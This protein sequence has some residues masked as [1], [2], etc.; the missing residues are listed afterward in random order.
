MKIDTLSFINILLSNHSPCVFHAHISVLVPPVV[1]A[2][3]D[4]FYKITSEALLVTQQ[5]VKV[6]R[7]LGKNRHITQCIIWHKIYPRD[8]MFQKSQ[9]MSLYQVQNMYTKFMFFSNDSNMLTTYTHTHTHT[10]TQ[11][12]CPSNNIEPPKYILWHIT[13][14]DI[15]VIGY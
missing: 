4:P 10:Y 15:D 5:L 3:G 14:C 7:P 8:F 6:I 12:F 1:T 11:L 9:D 13:V 2:V